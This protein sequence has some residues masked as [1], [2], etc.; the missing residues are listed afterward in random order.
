MRQL[1][2][3]RTMTV[4]LFALLFAL[5]ARVPVDTD[6]WWH[7]RSGEYILQHGIIY[8][9]PFSNT[10][11]GQPWI[12]HSWGAQLILY[13][14]WQGGGYLGLSVYM[15][16]LAT[17]GMY[18]VYRMCSGS[19]YL[20][21]F[22]LVLGAA[23]AAV[24]WSPRPQMLTFFLSTVVLYLLHSYKRE[25]KD[26]L[27]LI[28]I[29]MG[30][31]G[32][33]H[34]GFS[35]GFIF[36]FGYIVGETLDNLFNP[37]GEYVIGWRGVGKIA[38]VM[39]VSVA[40]LVVNPYGLQMLLVPFQTVSIGALQNFIQEWNSPNFHE[41]QTWPFVALLLGVLG[42]VGASR[43][44]LDW[45]DFVLVSGTAFMGLLAGRN[46]AVFAVAATPVLTHHLDS[47]LEERGWVLK[48]LQKTTRRMARLNVLLVIV[49]L[50]AA[51]TKTLVVLD[52]ETVSQAIEDY[53]PVEAVEFIEREQPPPP[54]FNS[55]NWGGY[56]LFALPDYPV[57]VDGRTDLYGDDFL[58]NRYFQTAIGATGWR[59][60]LDEY[61]INTVVVEAGS[62]L[63]RN[64]REEVG[65]LLDYE[66]EMA[67]VFVREGVNGES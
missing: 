40:A 56:I 47:L 55:Y 14:V 59:E 28:P 21:A 37:R 51:A 48:P 22:A 15:A 39:A 41:R 52:D 66:D 61:G 5:A 13:A 38:L 46:I 32:N 27:W 20:R 17:A 29:I 3:E 4:I 53:L 54:I 57:F 33:L 16:A 45:T 62:G 30:I 34:A 60:T 2:I 9:D 63:A 31:W 64:L 26:R 58:T 11:L 65:W 19:A 35:I 6:T 8:T 7:I 10:M 49:A 43:K 67:V 50:F 23:T 44:R 42:A 36:M 25:K 18:F 24:F 12:D 1:T